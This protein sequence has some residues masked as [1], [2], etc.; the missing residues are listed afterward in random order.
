VSGHWEAAV[1]AVMSASPV[2]WAWK[3]G[4]LEPYRHGEAKRVAGEQLTAALPHLRRHIIAELREK[5]EAEMDHVSLGKLIA[6]QF[7]GTPFPNLTD[8]AGAARWLAAQEAT[9]E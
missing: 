5:A 9:G 1:E 7:D 6:R 8:A 4:A 2:V 3:D